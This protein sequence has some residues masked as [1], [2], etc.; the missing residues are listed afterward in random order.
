MITNRLLDPKSSHRI[1]VKLN[2]N[3][4]L[5]LVLQQNRSERNFEALI[6]ENSW[7]ASLPS[8]AKNNCDYKE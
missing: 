5:A 4:N 6:S 7:R 1:G 2:G 3:L 8:T